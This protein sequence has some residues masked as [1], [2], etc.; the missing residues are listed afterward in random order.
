MPSTKS[1][2]T[3]DIRPLAALVAALASGGALAQKDPKTDDAQLKEV[4]VTATRGERDVYEV[5]ASA[6]VLDRKAL[7]DTLT[8]DLR[9]V[10]RDEPG[11]AVNNRPARFGTGSINIRGL[12]GNRVL[13]VT[14][15]VRSPDAFS[16][17]PF[18]QVGRDFTDLE[19]VDSVE[20]LRGPSSALYGSDALAGVVAFRT[21]D[22]RDVTGGRPWG[23]AVKPFYTG[24]DREGGVS[25]R[26]AVQGETLRLMLIAT[27]RRGA[28]RDNQ[29]T[30]GGTGAGRTQPNP[31]DTENRGLLAKLTLQPNAAH[32]FTLTA[33]DNR[34]EVES[35]V[36]SSVG[37]VA[38]GV[39]TDSF[40]ADDRTDRRRFSL[41]HRLDWTTRLFDRLHWTLYTQE[42]SARQEHVEQRLAIAAPG[43]PRQRLRS[44]TFEQDLDGL[45]LQLNRSFATAGISHLLTYGAEHDRIRTAA[46]RS[47]HEIVLATGAFVTGGA[48]FA[49]RDFAPTDT[50]MTGVFA[51]NEMFFA[52]GKLSVTAALRYDRYKLTPKPDAHTTGAPPRGL[53]DSAL[54]PRLGVM[55][56]VTPLFK[57]YAN[58]AQGY[59]APNYSE[60]NASFAFPA[61]GY[62]VAANPDLEP[63]N[64]R[65]LE[66]GM[67]GADARLGYQLAFFD[68]RYDDF[69]DSV[70][71]NCPPPV[72]NP[73]RDPHCSPL[74]PTTFQ[75]RNLTEVRIYGVE[76]RAE[77]RVAGNWRVKGHLAWH[78]GEDRSR[79]RPLDSINPARAGLA[80]AYAPGDWGMEARL[81]AAASNKRVDESFGPRFKAP[82]WHTLDLTAFARLG[83]SATLRVAANN[84]TDEKYWHAGDVRGLAPTAVALDRFTQPGRNFA[85]RFEYV[86]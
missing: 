27:A 5:P 8:A 71:L 12:E 16:F 54:T 6:S 40:D 80:L 26:A 78:R 10:F 52:G 29:G 72:G 25:V 11:L 63:E 3:R 33:E 62:A 18:F 34:G 85:A 86:F 36:L 14:D 58:Y 30:T 50:R 66:I 35:K 38:F 24:V 45:A 49:H 83:K 39:R 31:Q 74:V 84:L 43:V 28:E 55:Y 44:S 69:I 22:P 32:H 65:G 37:T 64:S 4:V 56:A 9:D 59:R 82:A 42:G 51:Q 23:A 60:A 61:M 67:K 17:G 70:T 81:A 2:P 15:G 1:K 76:A 57:P 75:S 68:N 46:L 48:P 21:P 13:I 73:A 19:T 7:D 79:N 47:G 20:I 53:K 77:Y 41:A